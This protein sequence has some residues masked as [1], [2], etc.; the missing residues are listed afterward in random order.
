MESKQAMSV[1][2]VKRQWVFMEQKHEKKGNG[3]L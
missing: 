2:G 3:Y 1:Y